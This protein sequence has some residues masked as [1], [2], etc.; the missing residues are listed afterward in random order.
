MRASADAHLAALG[1]SLGRTLDLGAEGTLELRFDDGLSVTL[2]RVAENALYV[3]TALG[4]APNEANALRALLE[5][6]F[7][8]SMGGLA[9]FA[10]DP[11]SAELLLMQD[12]DLSRCAPHEL[13]VVLGEFL[14][15]ARRWRERVPMIATK[16]AQTGRPDR[17]P[18]DRFGP[19]SPNDFSG[20]NFSALRA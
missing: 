11:S 9:R 1:A 5:A 3:Y 15:Q 19:S 20:S 14:V 6:H 12:I 16:T 18:P 2:E 7:F 4:N 13:P 17:E 8:G 10:I